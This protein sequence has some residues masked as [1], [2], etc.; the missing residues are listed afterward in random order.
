MIFARSR[1][2]SRASSAPVATPRAASAWTVASS[3]S[4]SQPAP[5]AAMPDASTCWASR[6]RKRS[7]IWSVQAAW[8]TGTRPAGTTNTVRRMPSI[9]TRERSSYSACSMA[10]LSTSRVRARAAR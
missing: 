1:G 3:A 10:D 7:A 5:S 9:R 8:I 6:R 4:L 2:S